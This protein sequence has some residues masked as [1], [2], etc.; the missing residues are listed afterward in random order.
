MRSLWIA[1]AAMAITLALGGCV[2]TVSYSSGTVIN[3]GY[4]PSR[5]IRGDGYSSIIMRGDNAY[6]NGH[7]GY[8]SQRAGYRAYQ[9]FWFPGVAFGGAV[10]IRGGDRPQ[11]PGY[12]GTQH[13]NWCTNRYRSYQFAD[14]TFN[15]GRSGRRICNSPYN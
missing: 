5:V 4:S 7:R 9:G 12:D 3:S 14:N 15:V 13:Q 1:S 6:Y 11:R 10:I 2:D 8:R